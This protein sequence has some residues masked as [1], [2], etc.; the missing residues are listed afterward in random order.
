MLKQ[1]KMFGLMLVLG[2]FV[3]T[4]SGCFALLVGA[5]AGA[6]GVAYVKGILEKNF[7]RSVAQVHRAS[8]TALKKLKMTIHDDDVTQHNA[9]IKATDTD[10]KK[11]EVIIE[12]LTEKSSKLQIRVGVFGDQEQS[13]SIL[14][15][16]QKHL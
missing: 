5:A 15:A 6:G 4:T 11:V 12:A 2:S 16:I 1:L 14:N 13:Q 7:D 9:K 3:I 8:L 10:G